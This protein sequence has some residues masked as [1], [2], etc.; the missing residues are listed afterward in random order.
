MDVRNNNKKIGEISYT[1]SIG[2]INNPYVVDTRQSSIRNTVTNR[3]EGSI[4]S[5]ER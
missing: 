3:A 5:L 4:G 1:L 2:N